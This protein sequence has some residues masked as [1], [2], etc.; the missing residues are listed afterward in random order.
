MAYMLFRRF[1][2]DVL[3]RLLDL[4]GDVIGFDKYFYS[5]L[6]TAMELLKI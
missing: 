6:D 2:G 1:F 5:D 3:E 4:M